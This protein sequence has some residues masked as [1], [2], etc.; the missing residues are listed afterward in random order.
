M[1]W[2]GCLLVAACTGGPALDI[3]VHH[4]AGFAVAQTRV[5]AY[6]GGDIDCGQI[7]FGD[8][9][10]AEL[11]A[12]KVDEV[13]AASGIPVEVSRLG[14]KSIVARGY[15]A[16]HRFV[17]AGCKDVG[18]IAGAIRVAIDTQ[19]TASVA[20]DPGQP[21]RPFSERDILVNMSDANG[22]AIDGTVSWLLTGPAGAAQQMASAG[23]PTRN[24]NVKFKVDDLGTPGPE[25][26]RIRAPWATAPLP[27][28]TGFDLSHA[29]TLPLGGGSLG[30]NPSCDVRGH[31]GKSP[32]L[33]CL[34]QADLQGHRDAVEIVWQ[35][36]QYAARP[37]SPPIPASIDNQF[38]LFVDHDGTADEPVY[39]L[40]AA[41]GGVGNWYKLGAPSGTTMTFDNSLQNVVYI[42]RCHENAPTAL[43]A[44][45]T[46]A[47][48]STANKVRFYTPSGGAAAAPLNTAMDGEVLSG[49]CLDDVD[50]KEHQG[51]V[52]AGPAVSGT[53][54]AAFAV[55]A[56][57]MPSGL[58][59]VSGRSLT[60][61]GFV[62]VSTQGMTEK[63]FAG[64]RLQASGTV[65]FEAVLAPDAGS[66]KLLER[67]ELDSAAPPN[68]IIAGKLDRDGDTDLMWDMLVGARRR[69]FQVS[70]AEQVGGTP[71]TAMT[72]GPGAV[73]ASAN[74]GGLD[75]VAA[76]LNGHGT[77]DMIV[78]GAA[79]VTI[80]SAD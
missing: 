73:G 70:L 46:G 6:F 66:F 8:R 28:V 57:I 56:L 9:S 47:V 35:N 13:D 1:R 4:P 75:F 24:G 31:A 7:E 17:T 25:G 55:L 49:G 43:V 54:D 61:S 72:S 71:L 50:K 11:A 36:G 45:Q 30:G 65:V 80:Y 34:G 79:S 51:V 20:I 33:I 41:A 23:T 3:S 59:A 12:I 19:P 37:F 62:T 40:S 15:D 78:F 27:L 42:P 32:T 67:T 58:T 21:D 16:Q 29:T 77:D 74:A 48:A 60:G 64:T 68:K 14:S 38:A 63:R 2:C 44:V 10:D 5:T 22:V 18:E 52:A 69:L 39:V 26:L 76:D 53:P